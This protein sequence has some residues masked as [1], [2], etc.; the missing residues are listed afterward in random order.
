MVENAMAVIPIDDDMVDDMVENFREG[1]GFGIPSV[2]GFSAPVSS[3]PS[4][5]ETDVKTVDATHTDESSDVILYPVAK[6]KIS[7]LMTKFNHMEWL[8]YLVGNEETNEVYDIV[9]PKQVV[10]VV[11][12][13]VRDDVDVPVMGVIHSHHDMGNKFSHTDD[14]FI[15]G[16]HDISLCVSHDGINGQVRFLM[17]DGNYMAVKANVIEPVDGFDIID[18]DKE[19]KDNITVKKITNHY[20]NQYIGVDLG[21]ESDVGYVSG[22]I[23]GADGIEYIVDKDP[24]Y[25]DNLVDNLFVCIKEE[26]T[27]LGELSQETVDE[28]TLLLVLMRSAGTNEYFELEDKLYYNNEECFEAITEDVFNIIDEVDLLTM[29]NKAEDKPLDNGIKVNI[30]KIIAFIEDYGIGVDKD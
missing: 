4:F 17:E 2:S 23:I 9:L 12:V 15:N 5:W 26:E 28:L 29:Y 18:F 22:T 19:I 30:N 25:F 8:A 13:D 11:H 1:M 14:E 20:N 27:T 7:Y 10:T 24:E 3:A 21:D 6:A 16:N